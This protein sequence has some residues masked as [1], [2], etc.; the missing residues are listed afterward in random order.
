MYG[1]DKGLR[2][3]E[4]PERLPEGVL[5][6]G[7]GAGGGHQAASPRGWE[8]GG[9]RRPARRGWDGLNAALSGRVVRSHLPRWAPTH[10]CGVRCPLLLGESVV[11]PCRFDPL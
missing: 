6:P 7:S 3:D 2:A 9:G 5:V 4:L 11:S 8:C 1:G 10:Q